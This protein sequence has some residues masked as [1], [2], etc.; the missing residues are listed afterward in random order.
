MGSVSEEGVGREGVVGVGGTE[1]GEEEERNLVGDVFG[2]VDL[3][4]VGR[5]WRGKVGVVGESCWGR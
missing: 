5:G 1:S 2:G 3:H 4:V